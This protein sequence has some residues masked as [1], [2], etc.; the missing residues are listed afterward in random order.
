MISLS[1]ALCLPGIPLDVK[2][3]M[4]KELTCT[5]LLMLI[6]VSAYKTQEMLA[7]RMHVAHASHWY[8]G[9]SGFIFAR[10]FC[11]Q[12]NTAQVYL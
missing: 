5:I 6:H 4:F 1:K 3:A 2:C 9:C 12:G 11:R 10:D 8:S 7:T